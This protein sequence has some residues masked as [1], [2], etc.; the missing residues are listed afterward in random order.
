MVEDTVRELRIR[1]GRLVSAHR[2][3][4]GWTQDEL[5]ARAEISIDMVSR[6]EAGATGA[7]FTTIDKLAQ[8]MGVDPA[9]FFSPHIPGSPADRPKLT[10]IMSRLAR[11]TDADLDWLDDVLA[12]VLKHR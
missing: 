4:L 11:L 1:F 10:A 8:A 9:E 3:R 5:S 7:R 12:A 6:M 2:R